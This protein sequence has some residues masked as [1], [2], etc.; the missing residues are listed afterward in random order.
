MPAMP[1]TE[2]RCAF[3]SSAQAWKS[4]LICRS[5]RSRPTNGASSPC[6]LSEPRRPE[7]TRRA[8][9]SGVR[10]LLALQLER[11]GLL[12]DDRL[13]GRA[14]RRVADEDR[15]RL[16]DRLDARRG[17][18]EVAGDHALALGAERDR[19]LAREHPGARAEFLAR[20]SR[21]PS[22]ETAATRSSAARTARS[23]SSS[24]AVGVPQTAITASPMN[25]STVPPYS[26]ISRRQVSK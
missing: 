14:A 8:R 2:T 22:A 19:G 1:V 3:R 15:A 4:S 16:G 5:S 9:Q 12:V 6:D 21:R 7:T 17:V 18:D 25:F 20:R 26:S 23:A 10:P 11:A 13:L 24:V